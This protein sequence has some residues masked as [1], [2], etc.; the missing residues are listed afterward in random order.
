MQKIDGLWDLGKMNV[1]GGG[2]RS[3]LELYPEDLLLDTSAWLRD[4][5]RTIRLYFEDAERLSMYLQR[6]NENLLERRSRAGLSYRVKLSCP[7]CR[8]EMFL[9][10]APFMSEA[11]GIETSRRAHARYCYNAPTPTVM[12]REFD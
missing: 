8:A 2:I 5:Q 3:G 12:A 6:S 1:V 9:T 7:V 11:D 10:I 4:S